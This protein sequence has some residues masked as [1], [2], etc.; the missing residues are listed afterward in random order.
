MSLGAVCAGSV[1]SWT[2]P[3]IPQLLQ[4]NGTN[5]T[6]SF[7]LKEGQE[8]LIGSLLTLGALFSSVPAGFIAEKLGRRKT[9]LAISIPFILSWILIIFANNPM[10]LFTGRFLCGIGTG[11]I[12]VCAPMYVGEIAHDSLRG[13]LAAFF[14][15]F[16]SAGILLT[17]V[18]AAFTNWIGLSAILTLVPI[19]FLVTFS[20]MPETPTYKVKIGDF[21]GARKSLEYFRGKYYN[22][23]EELNEIEKRITESMKKS[24]GF[25]DLFNSKAN[26]KA[27]IAAL[28]TMAF[29]Q[30]CGVNAIV[31][32][33]V[34]IFEAAS[35]VISPIQSAI[36]IALVQV[37][38]AYVDIFIME[39]ANRRFYLIL[40]STSML[41]CL[42][43]LGVY[44]HFKSIVVSYNGLGMLPIASAVLFM[45]GFSIGYGPVPWMIMAELFPSE[46][47]GIASGLAV[48]INWS[49]AFIV[50]FTFPLIKLNYGVHVAF[51]GFAILN[52]IATFFTYFCVPETK[53]K[54]L[55]QIQSLLNS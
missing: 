6:S 21:K 51:Y 35:S 14:Q 49:S 26:R 47:K 39:K 13:P 23:Q 41:I 27:L 33:T 24:A 10:M 53:G 31:F 18:I 29:Q 9:I 25:K 12:C 19:M 40:S 5:V 4:Q 52:F 2:S 45:I 8:G 38:I 20:F 36:I 1:L 3:V 46:I 28:G 30:L 42:T 48:L 37:I 15:M 7:T 43:S 50:T 32:Y 34:P 22:V 11:A 44:F 54:T 17:C 16:L 55:Q